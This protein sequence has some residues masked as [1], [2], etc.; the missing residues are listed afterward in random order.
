MDAEAQLQLYLDRAREP[1][2][3]GFPPLEA[4]WA[5]LLNEF[6]EPLHHAEA[7][8]DSAPRQLEPSSPRRRASDLEWFEGKFHEL[9]TMLSRRETDTS[10]IVS[11]NVKLARSLTAWT[12]FR[13]R[14]QARRPWPP[15]KRSLPSCHA[16]LRPRARKAPPMQTASRA[17]PRESWLRPRKPRRRAQRFRGHGAAHRQ[18]TRPNRRRVSLACGGGHGGADRGRP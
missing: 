6:T 13:P 11:I 3:K 16:R 5:Q 18:G 17:P 15:W 12:G 8:P 1:K 7:S 9:K 10:E 2:Q 4:L 14:F